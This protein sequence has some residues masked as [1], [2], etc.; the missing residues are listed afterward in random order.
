MESTLKWIIA[1][2]ILGNVKN[3]CVIKVCSM[4]L[5]KICQIFVSFT[6]I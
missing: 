1:A 3:I 2:R 5:P 6:I 4:T